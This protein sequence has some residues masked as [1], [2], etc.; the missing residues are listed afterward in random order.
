M[1]GIAAPTTRF[2]LYDFWRHVGA[3]FSDNVIMFLPAHPAFTV[4]DAGPGPFWGLIAGVA[5]QGVNPGRLTSGTR[6][7]MIGD[8]VAQTMI[9]DLA[10]G[11]VVTR[12]RAL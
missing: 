6:G 8:H 3:T 10:S 12:K 9:R 5:T 2:R 11:V 1:L 7:R 4:I